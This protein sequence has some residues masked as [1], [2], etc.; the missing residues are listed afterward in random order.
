MV[1]CDTDYDQ[2]ELERVFGDVAISIRG[3][4]APDRKEELHEA[5]IRGDRKV[6]ICKPVMFG[7]GLNWQHCCK[8]V[9][10][11]LSFSYESFYQAVR[12]CWRFRQTRDVH[13]H[14]VCAD[15]EASIWD[16][17]N[18]KSGDHTRMKAEMAAAMARAARQHRVLETYDPREGARLPA[19]M[20]P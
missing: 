5:W 10:C 17:V 19:W 2:D 4:M 16:V 15:T 18:R 9:F 7:F 3:S 14:V 1:W 6:I 20:M 13:A 8:M 12:R 11:G